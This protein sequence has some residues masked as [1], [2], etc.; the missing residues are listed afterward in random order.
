ML[1]PARALRAPRPELLFGAALAVALAAVGLRAGGGLAVGPTAKV[2][3]G[4]DVLG[5]LLGAIAA[6]AALRRRWWGAASVVLFAVLAIVTALSITWALQPSDAWLEANR[7]VAW[8]A[9]FASGVVL[10]RLGGAWWGA[11][12]G[13]ICTA[14]AVICAWAILTKVFPGAL[15]SDEIYARLRE[16][17]GYWNAVGLTAALGVPPALWLGARRSGHAAVNALAYPAMGLLLLTVLLAYSRGALLAVLIGCAFWFTIVPLRLRGATVLAVGAAGALIVSAWVFSQDT[18]TKDNVPLGERA[19]SGHELGIAVVAMFVVLTL[20]G[21]AIGFTA[22]RRAPSA[23]ARRRAGAAIVVALALVPVALVLALALS[24][25]GLGGSISSG[26][27]S[28]TD[29]NDQTKVANRPDRLTSVGSVRAR[30][31][32]ESLK[33][34][35]AHKLKGVGAGGYATA[36]LR[37]RTN[38]QLAVR[39]SH[40]YV[41]QTAADLGIVGL[42]ASLALLIAWAA[43]TGR[44]LGWRL[45]LPVGARRALTRPPPAP[46]HGAGP[47]YVGMATL[48]TVVLV[49]G[50]H[51]FVDWTWFVPGTA[52]IALLAAGWVAGRGPL[53]ERPVAVR[54][55]G[56][57]L[58]AGV[59]SPVRVGTA[60]LVLAL[61]VLAAWTAW[62]PQRSVEAGNAALL[63]AGPDAKAYTKARAL[64]DTAR[65]RNP[66][67][68]DPLFELA[69][70]ENVA[71]HKAAARQALVDAVRLQPSNAATWEQLSRFALDQ[72]DDPT[73][74]L[75]LLGPALY[76]DP[77]SPTGVRDYLDAL[78]RA[79]TKAQ[80]KARRRAAAK[81]K[82]QA[83]VR[84][85]A[86]RARRRTG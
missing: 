8:M 79:T 27:K 25:K 32:D 76:L 18:L 67:S 44:T 62:E 33:I 42:A 48:A 10:A 46:T 63:A 21:L 60:A 43:A 29:P 64:A 12:I 59:R 86:D 74:A 39:H 54:A 11:A 77:L 81:A 52:V 2:E 47:E 1:G 31:W 72:Q 16:P 41:V 84:R 71:G 13:A 80:E 49:F 68:P 24:S 85:K 15:A 38:G 3:I 45:P 6:L 40:G 56:P 30:Y 70:I 51:S 50:V 36:R 26:W 22:A 66:L 55:L 20:L 69:V 5:G 73:Q 28:L 82:R 83:A 19:T 7:T 9:V 4:L 61:G 37:Y 23:G 34:F 78:R 53:G 65:S 14:T 58:R 17:Y 75:R 35:K 57:A